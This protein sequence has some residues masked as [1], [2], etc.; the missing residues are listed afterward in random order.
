MFAPV[1]SITSK[2]LRITGQKIDKL[3]KIFQ[4]N[5]I[6]EKCILNIIKL[7]K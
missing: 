4:T 5:S 2:F 7:S 6:D 3:G 1:V